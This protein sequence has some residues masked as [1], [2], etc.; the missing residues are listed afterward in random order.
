MDQNKYNKLPDSHYVHSSAYA[1]LSQGAKIGSTD[2]STFRQ[3]LEL[4]RERQHIRNYSASSIG[5]NITRRRY[6]KSGLNRPSLRV[7]TPERERTIYRYEGQPIRPD[8]VGINKPQTNNA[9]NNQPQPR[10]QEPK[11][12]G[13]DPYA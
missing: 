6:A 1:K 3:R 12:R 10:F 4:E 9:A 5:N 11:S 2:Q 8:G 7:D 13:Y